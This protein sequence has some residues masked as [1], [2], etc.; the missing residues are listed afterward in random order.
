VFNLSTDR[1]ISHIALGPFQFHSESMRPIWETMNLHPT[2]LEAFLNT[3]ASILRGEGPL[4]DADRHY[5][6]MMVSRNRSV[7][8]PSPLV[9]CK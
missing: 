4:R 8:L 1:D 9:L 5:M 6:A 3:H 7:L 2:Y